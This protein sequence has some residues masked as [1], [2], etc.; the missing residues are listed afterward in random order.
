M[1][2][3]NKSLFKWSKTRDQDGRHA[4]IWYKHL[5]IFSGTSRPMTLKLGKQHGVLEY[6]QVCSNDDS[7]LTLTYFMAGQ[8]WSSMLL[9]GKKVNSGFFRNYCSL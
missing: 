5:K 1:G 6:Y 9:Y 7:G 2:W 3:E 8:I 4:H